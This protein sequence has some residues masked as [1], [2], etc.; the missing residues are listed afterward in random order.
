MSEDITLL[1]QRIDELEDINRLALTLGSTINVDEIL[2]AI[3][4]SSLKLCLAERAAILLFSPSSNEVVKTL[5]R[6]SNRSCE[7]I[8]HKLNLIVAGRIE[9]S[10]KPLITDNI[11]K[12]TGYK[13]PSARL[14]EFGPAL[15]VP[16]LAEGKTIGIIHL[17]NS[18]GG[19]QFSKDLVRIAGVIATLAAQFIHRAKLQEALFEDNRRLKDR[20]SVV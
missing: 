13:N 19:V 15:A 3:I 12:E 18:R 7:G 8:D 1:K 20:K 9:R 6:N 4:D 16:L 11:I 2:S 14:Q 17:V 5:M 10:G